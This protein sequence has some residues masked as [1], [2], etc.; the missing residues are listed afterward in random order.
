MI[1]GEESTTM[2][3]IPM[4]EEEMDN[5]MNCM[6]K[7]CADLSQEI[8]V[9]NQQRDENRKIAE[10]KKRRRQQFLGF[11]ILLVAVLAGAL[12]YKEKFGMF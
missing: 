12:F 5:C 9:R 2:K 11:V 7:M 6:E 8:A 10:K 1:G 3:S 4:I